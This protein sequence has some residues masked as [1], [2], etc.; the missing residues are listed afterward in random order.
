MSDE[1]DAL[2]RA[3]ALALVQLDNKAGWA[4]TDD[5]TTLKRHEK[6]RTDLVDALKAYHATKPVATVK[7]ETA[8]LKPAAAP[9]GNS[10]SLNWTED[11]GQENGRYVNRCT[12][13][14][15][16]F[17]GHKRRVTCKKCATAEQR[18]STMVIGHNR[19]PSGVRAEC[20]WPLPG[21]E[22]NG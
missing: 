14:G 15:F 17:V 2:A 13:C 12:T 7:D 1:G 21:E 6:A 8:A 3:V 4:F 20:C 18:G 5:S 16:H 22:P 9:D 19:I 11:Y 10:E